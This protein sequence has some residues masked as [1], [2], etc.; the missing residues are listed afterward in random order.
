MSTSSEQ[1]TKRRSRKENMRIFFYSIVK[2]TRSYDSQ[3]W[4]TRFGEIY[5]SRKGLW[6]FFLDCAFGMQIGW[7]GDH[8]EFLSS[9]RNIICKL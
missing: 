8:M 4:Q 9:D 2:I 1:S 6:A 5:E 3:I 7:A